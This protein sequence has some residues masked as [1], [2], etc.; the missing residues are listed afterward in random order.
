MWCAFF[1]RQSLYSNATHALMNARQSFWIM[2]V[3][4]SPAFSIIIYFPCVTRSLTVIAKVWQALQGVTGPVQFKIYIKILLNCMTELCLIFNI[5]SHRLKSFKKIYQT[6]EILRVHQSPEFSIIFKYFF[7]YFFK[8][9][10]FK[11][12]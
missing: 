6:N 10:L 2:R 1:S 11:N 3:H 4:Q 7:I 8:Y 9:I 5:L 12:L